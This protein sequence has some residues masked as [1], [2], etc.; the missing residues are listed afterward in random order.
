MVNEYDPEAIPWQ[1]DSWLKNKLNKVQDGS[2]QQDIKVQEF[3]EYFENFQK[4]YCGHFDGIDG[5]FTERVQSLKQ[6]E[7]KLQ[8]QASEITTQIEENS[9]TKAELDKRLAEVKRNNEAIQARI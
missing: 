1:P 5:V 6:L 9:R 2:D 4:H 7:E 8:N 3:I